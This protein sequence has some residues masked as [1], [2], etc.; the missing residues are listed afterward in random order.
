MLCSR[1]KKF[2]TTTVGASGV[3]AYIKGLQKVGTMP[4][5]LERFSLPF[6]HVA[7]HDFKRIPGYSGFVPG[8]KCKEK[9]TMMENGRMTERLGNIL[10]RNIGSS[11]FGGA[12]VDSTMPRSVADEIYSYKVNPEPLTQF[13]R[14]RTDVWPTVKDMFTE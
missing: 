12:Y 7:R 4:L 5:P 1:Q 14:V 6:D 3:D 13:S 10:S 9:V 2:S 8:D 11:L